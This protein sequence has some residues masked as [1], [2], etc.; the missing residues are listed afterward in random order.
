MALAVALK[1]HYGLGH[2][3]R[4][5]LRAFHLAMS[6]ASRRLVSLELQARWLDNSIG[7]LAPTAA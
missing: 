7:F 6:N 1:V 2:D 5:I 3:F 4:R